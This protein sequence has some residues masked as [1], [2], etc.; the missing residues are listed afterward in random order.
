MT[1]TAQWSKRHSAGLALFAAGLVLVGVASQPGPMLWAWIVTMLLIAGCASVIGQGI[2]GRWIGLLIDERNMISLSQLQM[3]IWTLLAASA[4]Y[5]VFLSNLKG[6]FPA[7][8]HIGI[9]QELLLLMG[10]TTTSLVASPLIKGAMKARE[11]HKK[12]PKNERLDALRNTSPPSVDL[13]GVLVINLT[14]EPSWSDL[15]NGEEA[16]NFGQ[17]DLG[18]AQ[19]FYFTVIIAIAYA[20]VLG[21]TLSAQPVVPITALPPLDTTLAELLGISNGGYLLY[22]AVP[23]TRTQ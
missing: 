10:A 9:P 4:L 11:G 18:K 21:A 6:N 20:L 19:L 17:T 2:K 15:F 22:K 1:G 5:A 8:L 12:N 7:P 14:R 16:G 3:A 13:S 23:H